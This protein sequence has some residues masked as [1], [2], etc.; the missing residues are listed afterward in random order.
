MKE[1][2]EEVVVIVERWKW[3]ERKMN[4]GLYWELVEW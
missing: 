4:N 1:V 2:P 3:R